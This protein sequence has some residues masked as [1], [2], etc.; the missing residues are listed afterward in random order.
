MKNLTLTVASS[1][2]IIDFLAF[3]DKIANHTCRDSDDK[4]Y[5]NVHCKHPFT[6]ARL[7]LQ[8]VCL[9]FATPCN[10]I[11]TNSFLFSLSAFQQIG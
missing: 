5:K 6:V 10:I 11:K 2:F 7:S 4:R 1:Q 9:T 3:A 8:V